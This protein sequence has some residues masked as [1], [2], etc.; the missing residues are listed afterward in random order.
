MVSIED[1]YSTYGRNLQASEIRRLFAISIKPG[2]ISFAG[3]LPDPAS[4]PSDEMA[5]VLDRLLRERG[6][7]LLQ[8]GA[9][10][11]SQEGIQTVLKRMHRQGIN[12][13]ES[14]IIVTNGAQQA[15][16]LA[17]RVLTDPGDII[18]TES[19]TF[20]G[21]LG[22]FRNAR[23]SII[24][25]EIDE[26]GIIPDKLR[27]AIDNL[28]NKKIKFLYTIPA[29]HNPTGITLSP[30][31]R[32]EIYQIADDNDILILEDSPYG[33]LWFDEDY[34]N[35]PTLK[36]LDTNGRV[37]YTGSFSKIISPGIRLGWAAA[38]KQ[39]IDRFDMAK[40]MLD[41]CPSPLI[42]AAAAELS[43]SGY[44]DEHI[45]K[46][47]NIYK[48]RCRAMLDALDEYMP[49]GVSWTHPKG[50]FYIWVT[51]PEN[52]DAM[53]MLNTALANNVAYVIGSAFYPDGSG[54]N[55]LRV[56]FSNESEEVINEG[57]KRLGITV[58]QT[59]Q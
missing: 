38:D 11:G 28:N 54:K 31:R 55:R 30:E 22:I 6:S 14:E 10:R 18:L 4:F 15:I 42:Q 34:E 3:G 1:K 12:A 29:F 47:R 26:N 8:Y 49:D 59:L 50:G 44:L 57:I 9:S 32:K 39:L 35:M 41:V 16:D 5:D 19:P 7:T 21:A 43:E 25:V 58:R 24:G 53:E 52:V 40:Q 36:S 13:D 48:L 51:L 33:E 17:A 56:S 46:L 27:A 45:N 23:A 37:I 20:I 2:V